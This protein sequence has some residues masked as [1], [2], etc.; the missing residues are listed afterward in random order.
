M[1]LRWLFH[2]A[3][4]F[5]DLVVHVFDHGGSIIAITTLLL[6]ILVHQLLQLVYVLLIK[7][8]LPLH[9][10]QVW[11]DAFNFTFA[12]SVQ[13]I[14]FLLL[15]INLFLHFRAFSLRHIGHPSVLLLH[16]VNRAMLST[17]LLSK[18]SLHL[19]RVLNICLPSF[20]LHLILFRLTFQD[21]S[22][23]L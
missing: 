9:I 8:N 1:V 15:S 3:G 18:L 10:A 17:V 13:N 2:L 19:T 14:G 16:F 4:L 21:S 7:V 23:H 5:F 12:S 11:R 22:S 6:V 20:I